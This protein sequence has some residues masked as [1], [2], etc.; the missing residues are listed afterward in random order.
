MIRFE[1]AVLLSRKNLSFSPTTFCTMPSTSELESLVLVW[2][3]KRG[4]ET[5]TD[6]TATRPSRTS[7]PVIAGSFSLIRLLLRAKLLMTRVSAVLKP[8]RRVPPSRL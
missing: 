7:S 1:T 6:T 2:P 8:D 3:S 5:L 4:S